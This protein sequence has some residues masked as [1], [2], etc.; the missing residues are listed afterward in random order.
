MYFSV[1][2]E[3]APTRE[4]KAALF[5]AGLGERKITFIK[6][7]DNSLFK[8]K[9]EEVFPKLCDCGGYDLL[10]T[11]VGSKY[12]LTGIPIP[13]TGYSSQQLADQS[14]LGQALCY[15]RPMQKDIDMDPPDEQ[16]VSE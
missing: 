5:N 13:S 4:E 7:A 8:R 12:E 11:V 14:N 16:D 10:R 6:S 2:K 9:L 15:V 1:S 3:V